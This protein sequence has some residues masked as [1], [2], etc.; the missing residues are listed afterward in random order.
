[1]PVV[2]PGHRTSETNRHTKEEERYSKRKKENPGD[3]D[4]QIERA[5]QVQDETVLVA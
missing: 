2:L 3:R 4:R 5:E 1:M